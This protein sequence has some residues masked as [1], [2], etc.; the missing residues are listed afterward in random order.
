M[1]VIAM[2]KTKSAILE[3]VHETAMGLHNAGVMDQ[4]ALREFDQL[5]LLSVANA[6]TEEMRQFCARCVQED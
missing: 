1:E 6:T 4:V 2:R 3:A 5:C